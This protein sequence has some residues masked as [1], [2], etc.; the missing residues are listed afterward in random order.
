MGEA[1]VDNLNCSDGELD[2]WEMSLS[3]SLALELG[4]L[5]WDFDTLD[6]GLDT[7]EGVLGSSIVR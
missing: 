1:Y 5:G 6:L 2:F 7:Q 4:S 3:G